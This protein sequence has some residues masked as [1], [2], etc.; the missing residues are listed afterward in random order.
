MRM[1]SDD[2]RPPPSGKTHTWTE[3]SA[4]EVLVELGV[5]SASEDPAQVLSILLTE[6]STREFLRIE[7]SDTPGQEA[8]LEYLVAGTRIFV[9]KTRLKEFRG[10]VIAGLGVWA[11]SN[12]LTWSA[13]AALFRKGVSSIRHLSEDEVE[14]VRI[15]VRR[16]RGDRVIPTA[17][18]A[19][20]Y[21][22]DRESLSRILSSL[23]RQGVLWQEGDGWRLAP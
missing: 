2:N 1:T 3:L 17:T 10:D 5:G 20:A 11:L 7:P 8:R 23:A 18:I 13:A 16:A 21:A 14:V 9:D 6:P 4:A 12:S 15:V 22:G 19:R